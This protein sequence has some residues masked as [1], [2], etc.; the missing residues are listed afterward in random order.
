LWRIFLRF[1]RKIFLRFRLKV[2][3]KEYE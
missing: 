1:Y 2:K 3:L